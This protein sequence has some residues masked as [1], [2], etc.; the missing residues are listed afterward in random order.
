[1]AIDSVSPALDLNR[2]ALAAALEAVA[3]VTPHDLHRPTPCAGW[4]VESL[5][6]HMTG[7][8]RGFATS[9]RGARPQRQDFAPA[10]DAD[11]IAGYRA[12]SG[13][14]ER[15]FSGLGSSAVLWLPELSEERPFP[16]P[17]AVGFHT[18]DYVIHAW[19]VARSVGY[20]L[21]VPNAVV[22]PALALA[23][24]LPAPRGPGAPFLAEVETRAGMDSLEELL[25]W[26]GRNPTL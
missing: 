10:Q 13:Q 18:I 24:S 9:A 5:L 14:V 25:A 7:Q 26:S 16:A 3:Q 8:H 1:M 20:H 22:E 23:R 6:R 19:D 11:P 12:A 2:G 4:D 15:A 21:R 17:L